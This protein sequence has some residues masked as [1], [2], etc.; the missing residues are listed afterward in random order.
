MAGGVSRTP[1]AVCLRGSERALL[2][3]RAPGPQTGLTHN[4]PQ[5]TSDTS[6]HL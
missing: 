5:T 1:E 3:G 2:D 4:A 6:S